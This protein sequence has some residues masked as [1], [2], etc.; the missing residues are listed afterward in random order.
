MPR[1]TFNKIIKVIYEIYKYI[2]IIILVSVILLSISFSSCEDNEDNSFEIFY[3]KDKA[4]TYEQAYKKSIQNLELDIIPFITSD[5]IDFIEKKYYSESKATHYHLNL[6]ENTDQKWSEEVLPFVIKINDEKYCLGEYWPAFTN[7]YPKSIVM[8]RYN[9]LGFELMPGSD[10]GREMLN[11]PI[12]E[13]TF[14]KLGI[15]IQ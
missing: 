3:L 6:K 11:D 12:I 13:R 10:N 2:P 14:K 7:I 8:Y 1:Y 5:N 4:L 9:K 15:S